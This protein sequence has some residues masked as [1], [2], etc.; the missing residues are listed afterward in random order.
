MALRHCDLGQLLLRRAVLVHVPAG[1]DGVV[2]DPGS[3][4]DV[5]VGAAQPGHVGD[6]GV[7]VGAGVPGD[8]PG[9]DGGDHHDRRHSVGDGQGSEADA[10]GLP[11]RPDAR[12]GVEAQGVA[13]EVRHRTAGQPRAQTHPRGGIADEAVDIG[14]GEAGI[15][16]RLLDDL[17]VD[18]GRLAIT[19]VALLC[20]GDARERR[21]P[22]LRHD[23]TVAVAIRLGRWRPLPSFSGTFVLGRWAGRTGWNKARPITSVRAGS[24]SARRRCRSAWRVSRR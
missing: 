22:E 19:Q 4:P 8:L 23:G 11:G 6:G 9:G 17:P 2:G 20:H 24:Q 15:G 10:G 13:D 5:L 14:E 16:E 7:A 12:G 18:V 3:A 1:D 21:V